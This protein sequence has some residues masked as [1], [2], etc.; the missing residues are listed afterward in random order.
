MARIVVTTR[1]PDV[2]LT[3]LHQRASVMELDERGEVPDRVLGDAEGLVVGSYTN[4]DAALLASAPHLKVVGRAGVGLDNIDL[5]AC[6][7]RGVVVVHTPNANT[8]AVCEYVIALMLDAFRPRVS[9]NPGDDVRRYLAYRRSHVGDQL[10]T[11]TLGILGFGRIGRRLGRMAHAIGMRVMAHDLLDA[12]V[13][14]PQIDFPVELVTAEAMYRTCDVLTIHVDG[15]SGNRHLVDAKVLAQLKSSCLIINAS[16]GPIVDA[17]ALAKWARD[18]A[19]QGAAAVLDVHDPEPLPPEPPACYPL[20]G[21]PNVRLLPHLASRTHR[22]V[23]NMGWV[24]RDLIA[25][26]DG[27][28]PSHPAW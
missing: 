15:R 6:Q 27:A 12:S 21:L 20:Y 14:L 24:V 28:A 23:E 4:I 26:I 1:L 8:Q 18:C 3:W 17:E 9:L 19:P 5:A 10:D 2:C 13:L 16:R 7:Q 22:A 11:M 25:V